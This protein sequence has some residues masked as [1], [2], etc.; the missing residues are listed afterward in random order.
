[1]LFTAAVFV[2]PAALINLAVGKWG[3]RH[4]ALSWWRLALFVLLGSAV[5]WLIYVVVW[6]VG[7]T[8]ETS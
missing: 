6:I 1:M 3:P 7:L 8:I 5:C 2:V 4:Q